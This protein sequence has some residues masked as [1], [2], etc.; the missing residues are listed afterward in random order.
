MEIKG[1][2]FLV[3]IYYLFLV[4]MSVFEFFQVY[5][6]KAIFRTLMRPWCKSTSWRKALWTSFAHFLPD[7]SLQVHKEMLTIA[8]GRGISGQGSVFSFKSGH[9]RENVGMKS[10]DH[11]ECRVKMEET[12]HVLGWAPVPTSASPPAHGVWIT[13]IFL[14]GDSSVAWRDAHT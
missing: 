12:Q 5:N 9:G 1:K 13:R 3:F 11:M 2:F 7:P 10:P 14:S 6:F 4:Y 8:Q